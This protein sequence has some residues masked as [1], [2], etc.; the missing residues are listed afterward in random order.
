MYLERMDLYFTV[1]EI[2][3]GRRVAIFLSVIGAKTD[4]VSS[5][6]I[7]DKGFEQ[8]ADVLKKHFEPKSFIIAKRFT[9]HHR[10][11]SIQ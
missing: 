8:F 9:F 1:N 11:Q 5:V 6:R 7:K 2:A 3:K 4:L 10:N